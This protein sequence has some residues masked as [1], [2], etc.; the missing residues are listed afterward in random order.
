MFVQ[1]N[2][3]EARSQISAALVDLRFR[4][5]AC[6]TAALDVVEAICRRIRAP[7]DYQVAA[8]GFFVRANIRL[9][10]SRKLSFPTLVGRFTHALLQA[11]L[12]DGPLVDAFVVS[13]EN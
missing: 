2:A 4:A 10:S 3:L 7:R 13:Q 6:E 12:G 8:I 5:D 9:F 1:S 11:P